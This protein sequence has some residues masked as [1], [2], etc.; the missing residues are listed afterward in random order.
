MPSKAAVEILYSQGLFYYQYYGHS[1][2]GYALRFLGLGKG[3][4][5]YQ[6]LS[7]CRG[8]LEAGE[9]L[10]GLLF[11][12]PETFLNPYRGYKTSRVPWAPPIGKRIG[13]KGGGWFFAP[14][15]L[16]NAATAYWLRGYTQQALGLLTVQWQWIKDHLPLDEYP[17]HWSGEQT[18]ACR[19]YFREADAEISLAVAKILCNLGRNDGWTQA[20]QIC[21]P[22]LR[23]SLPASQQQLALA[24]F[25]ATNIRHYRHFGTGC[26]LP[27]A[28]VPPIVG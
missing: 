16:L 12:K 13:D 15:L 26:Q 19:T 2:A 3:R 5:A 27:P 23:E 20:M 1:D 7:L 24:R 10:W 22:Y 21:Q 9:N 11:W 18:D 28:C 25:I 4:A 6:W 14:D 17:E 8:S